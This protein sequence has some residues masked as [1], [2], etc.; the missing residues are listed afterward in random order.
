MAFVG[1]SLTGGEVGPASPPRRGYN[2]QDTDERDQERADAR[3]S[4]GI[5]L[6]HKVDM[7]L[8]HSLTQTSACIR[9]KFALRG[10][11]RYI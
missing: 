11:T 10:A 9:V 1:V 2:C 7:F 3:P 6:N 5:P 4:H 8:R